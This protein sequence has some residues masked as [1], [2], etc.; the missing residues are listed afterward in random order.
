MKKKNHIEIYFG[1]FK[2]LS[3][4]FKGFNFHNC[5]IFLNLI[6]QFEH[7]NKIEKKTERE[8]ILSAWEFSKIFNFDIKKSYECIED[9]INKLMKTHIEINNISEYTLINV[10]SSAEYNE[11]KGTI[12]VKFTDEIM[13]YL[14][15]IKQSFLSLE[16]R[17]K[18]HFPK[19][20]Q[21]ITND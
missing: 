5:Q 17:T 16:N 12:I 1:D 6:N 20:I 18:N 15:L 9:A 8:Y 21:S 13:P 4:N 7:S 11:N 2:V 14:S 10:C 19:N 3:H